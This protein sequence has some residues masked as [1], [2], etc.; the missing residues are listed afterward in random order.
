MQDETTRRLQQQCDEAQ[1][2]L[3]MTAEQYRHT[4]ARLVQAQQAQQEQERLEQERRAQQER[5]EQERRDK[6]LPELPECLICMEP[7]H[8]NHCIVP[9]GHGNFCQPCLDALVAR[10]Q[11]CPTCRGSIRS[12]VPLF[13]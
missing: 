9:C 1:R 2:V 4:Q 8:R 7:L 13:I 10:G 12:I 6:Q 5:W 11:K 3:D